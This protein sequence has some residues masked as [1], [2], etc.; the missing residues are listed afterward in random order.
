LDSQSRFALRALVG[1]TDFAADAVTV[2]GRSGSAAI[3]DGEQ[4]SHGVF[5]T[6]NRPLAQ[7][8]T[9][10]V[11]I[12]GDR[13]ESKNRGGFFSARA[14]SAD[15]LSGNVAL[16]CSLPSGWTATAQVARGFRV[17]TLSDRYFRGPSGRGFVTGNPDLDPETSLQSDLALRRAAGRTAIGIY[18]YRYDIDD[19]VER[20][21]DGDNFFFRNRGEARVEGLEAEAQAR[22]HGGL[23]L[24][25]GAS[26]IRSRAA[27][28]DALDDAPAPGAWLTARYTTARAYGFARVAG[29]DRKDD[30][31]PTE[32][33]RPGYALIDIGGGYHVT[34]AVE[35][36]LA[37]R[38]ALDRQYTASPDVTA[39][40]SPGRTLTLGVSGR[41]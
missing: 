13:I 20:F 4:T 37:V 34:A 24:E 36:R 9:L 30:P 16:S 31:G 1:R 38:N 11:G 41:F 26:F 5:G 39:D 28:G 32:T 35:L 10:G 6:W 22:L 33:E 23:S 29:F 18:A 14:E 19:L 3:E 7:R 15:A 21:A 25:A 27:G 40:R 17:P 2:T 8:W 12:R